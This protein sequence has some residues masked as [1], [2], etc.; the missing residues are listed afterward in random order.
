METSAEQAPPP[1]P[2]AFLTGRPE[3]RVR[4]LLAFAMAA[5]AG[6]IGHAGI[7]RAIE[8]Y[9]RKADGELNAH[10]MTILQT[11]VQ[12]IRR[13]AAAQAMARAG[14]PVGFGLVFLAALLAALI[15]GGTGAWLLA[16]MVPPPSTGLG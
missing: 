9:R 2:K 14:R 4:D 12:E 1:G 16:G 15:V 13:D 3:D 10:A 11:R 6:A 7:E 8:G 5:D